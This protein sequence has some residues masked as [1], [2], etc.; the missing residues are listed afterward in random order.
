M[1]RIRDLRDSSGATAVEFALTAPAFFALVAGIIEVGIVL[2][3][4]LSLQQGVEAAARCASVNKTLCGTTSE[5]Q[6]YAAAQSYGLTPATS[7]FTVSTPSCGNQV[8]ASYTYT[9]LFGY[10]DL[11]NITLT[12]RSCFP[13]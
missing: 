2:W 5:I 9:F 4:Q 11:P 12:A 1:K 6:S 10:F 7:T 13:K 8:S 3:S